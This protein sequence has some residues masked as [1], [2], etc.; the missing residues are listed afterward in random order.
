MTSSRRQHRHRTTA[1]IRYEW[2]KLRSLRSTWF[3]V[4]GL[5]VVTGIAGIDGVHAAFRANENAKADPVYGTVGITYAQYL[6]LVLGVLSVTAEFGTGAIRG[7]LL[8]VPRRMSF[9]AAK[10]FVAGALAFAVASAYVIIDLV[11]EQLLVP[12]STVGVGTVPLLRAALG[13]PLYLALI[14]LLGV[15]VGTAVRSSAAA[16]TLLGAL[17]LGA[18]Q[19]VDARWLPE[20]GTALARVGHGSAHA[21]W[22]GLVAVTAWAAVCLVAG[23]EALRRFEG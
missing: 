3:I 7:S 13:V 4:G 8:V 20:A 2:I 11:L 22:T 12:R 9:Y 18:D 17:F 23:A 16:L 15:G 6:A 5:L 21:A 14:T 1:L 19:L 10:A